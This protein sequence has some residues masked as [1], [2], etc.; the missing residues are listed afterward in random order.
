[1]RL[2]RRRFLRGSAGLLLAMP[3]LE[4]LASRGAKANE[5]TAPTRVIW[6]VSPNGQN[7]DDWVPAQEGSNYT[8]SPILEPLQPYKDKLTVV[9]GLRNYG[10]GPSEYGDFN[11]G[12]SGY[13]V[14][15]SCRGLTNSSLN[16]ITVDQLLAQEVG[17]Q[18]MFPSLQVGM[19]GA[20]SSTKGCIS[21]AGPG[22]PLP[23]TSSPASLF[24]RL[25]GGNKNL[26]EEEKAQRKKLRLSILD[27]VV[28]DLDHLNARLPHRDRLKLDQFTT[29]MRELEKR[30]NK[31][32]LA[33]CNPGE[34]PGTNLDYPEKHDRMM[35]V[36]TLAI[37]CDLSRVMTFML[38]AG[39]SNQTHTFAGVAESHHG[40]S[41]HAYDPVKLAKLTKIG[42]WQ[43]EA[44]KTGLID[45]LAATKDIDGRT[46]LDNTIVV[47][48]SPM[49]DSHYHNNWDL[50]MTVIGGTDHFKHGQHLAAKD[51]PL[52]DLHIAVAQAAGSTLSALG[53]AGTG[54]LSGLS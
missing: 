34:S 45:R 3:L 39:G 46:L 42:R 48:G 14:V 33:T 5:N 52:A 51:K 18:T 22:I 15:L 11:E 40:L 2:N 27:S 16:D 7:M 53:E 44:I 4:S 24:A 29:S 10:C 21:W 26:S 31:P 38:G 32:T 6:W 20:T 54:P 41:H 35:A 19:L 49:G 25:F 23:L 17:N 8:L 12:H 30:L 13:G 36:M 9:S 28:D 1:M 43:S 37:Q 50:P 47:T